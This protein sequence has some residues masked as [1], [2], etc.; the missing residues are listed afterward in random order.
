[1]ECTTYLLEEVKEIKVLGRTTA[2]RKP[3]TLFWTGSGIECNVRASELWVEIEADYDSY[4]PW[5]SVVINGVYVS[6][7]MLNKGREWICLFRGMNQEIVKNVKVLKEV[8]A[9]S[10]DEKHCMQIHAIRIDGSFLPVGEKP[11][12]IE[13][14]G[15]SITSGEGSIGATIEEDW[16]SMWFSTQNNYA[17]M[18]GD[19]LNAEC[20][21]ISQSGWGVYSAWD[22]NPNG[23]IPT[24][25]EKVCGLL[26]G[27]KNK[28]LGALNE[29][30]FSSWQPDAIVIN[31]GTNDGGAFN[32]P[33]WKD[34]ETGKVYKQRLNEDG[35]YDEEDLRHFKNAVVAFLNKIRKYNPKTE[36]LW[37][38][39]MLGTPM[40]SSIEE[41]K[42]SSFLFLS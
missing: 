5:M 12:K 35:T 38:Y 4:E 37:A 27:E 15:D 19:A 36:L 13:F 22:N 18:I 10:G 33:E 9:M 8:Q 29:N 24:Y 3:L 42:T 30:D 31:L 41:A 28:A 23:A 32:S 7:R 11:Y 6:R 26:K 39:G 16:I 25:Y 40:L 2:N 20:R 34:V 14:I 21:F 1:M 17:R